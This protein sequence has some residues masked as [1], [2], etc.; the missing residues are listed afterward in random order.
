MTSSQGAVPSD[1]ADKAVAS[2]VKDMSISESIGNR[3]QV[4]DSVTRD[5]EL[6]GHS[7]D[8][9][10]ATYPLQKLGEVSVIHLAKLHTHQFIIM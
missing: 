5:D 4:S 8:A 1:L 6:I 9:M 2:G 7:K 3:S 10:D